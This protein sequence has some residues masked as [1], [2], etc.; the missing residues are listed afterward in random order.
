MDMDQ[1]S[2]P[3]YPEVT[4]NG[5]AFPPLH[6]QATSAV[7]V[8]A[9]SVD[10]SN[11][12]PH[13]MGYQPDPHQHIYAQSYP[14]YVPT[15]PISTG[16]SLMSSSLTKPN[17]MNLKAVCAASLVVAFAGQFVWTFSAPIL[18][19]AP[20][21]IGLLVFL[22][23][24]TLLLYRT[25][26]LDRFRW[27]TAFVAA[28]LPQVAGLYVIA[29]RVL[30]IGLNTDFGAKIRIAQTLLGLS[31]LFAAVAAAAVTVLPTKSSVVNGAH[32][33]VVLV[34]WGVLLISRAY[35]ISSLEGT[36]ATG[37]LGILICLVGVISAL[38]L[39]SQSTRAPLPS[40]KAT[41]YYR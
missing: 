18:S 40:Y 12:Q 33:L 23:V 30:H 22:P 39:E 3:S 20:M 27:S 35:V 13:P 24:A 36:I 2:R 14:L 32:K 1:C 28:F 34:G 25:D 10:Q 31:F 9:H 5:L 15:Q 7:Y 38:Y 16:P 6:S 21:V 8:Q 19:L 41:T 37:I 26:P 17:S 11:S 4:D 29:E